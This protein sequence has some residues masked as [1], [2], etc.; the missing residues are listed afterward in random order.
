MTTL[1]KIKR[2]IENVKKGKYLRKITINEY[3]EYFKLKGYQNVHSL[4]LDRATKLYDLEKQKVAEIKKVAKQNNI[5]VSKKTKKDLINALIKSKTKHLKY[6]E[7]HFKKENKK[8]MDEYKQIIKERNI[9]KKYSLEV[10]ANI[11]DNPSYVKDNGEWIKAE[12]KNWYTLNFIIQNGIILTNIR[13][14]KQ[15]EKG[16]IGK[17]HPEI[18]I[19]KYIKLIDETKD[20]NEIKWTVKNDLTKD[21]SSYNTIN[22]YDEYGNFNFDCIWHYITGIFDYGGY[23]KQIYK[24]DIKDLKIINDIKTAD[25]KMKRVSFQYKFLNSLNGFVETEYDDYYCA[26]RYILEECSGKERLIK[27]TEKEF[28]KQLNRLSINFSKGL[29]TNDILKWVKE[30]YADIISMHAISPLLTEFRRH[31]APNCIVNLVYIVNNEHLYPIKNEKLKLFISK[32]KRVDE[33]IFLKFNYTGL[34]YININDENQYNDLLNSK[35]NNA[36]VL[37]DDVEK[38]ATDYINKNNMLLVPAS[39]KIQNSKLVSFITDNGVIVESNCDYESRK[40]ICQTFKGLYDCYNLEFRNQTYAQLALELFNIFHGKL[41]NSEYCEETRNSFDMFNI[42]PLSSTLVKNFEYDPNLDIALDLNRCY[43]NAMIHNTD[44]YPVFTFIDEIKDYDDSDIICGLYLVDNVVIEKLGGLRFPKQWI[45]YTEVKFMLDNDLITKQNILQYIKATNKIAANKLGDFMKLLMDT[46]PSKTFHDDAKLLCN[47]FIGSLGKKYKNIDSGFITNSWDQTC[48]SYLENLNEGKEFT[49][50]S[51][52]GLYFCRT[53]EKIRLFSDNVPIY[54][55]ILSYSHI[56]LYKTILTFYKQGNSQLLGYK[57]DFIYIRK[58]QLL[59]PIEI[60]N[61]MI[62]E[63]KKNKIY[64]ENGEFIGLIDP[65]KKE[66][67]MPIEVEHPTF[68]HFDNNPIGIKVQFGNLPVY[69]KFEPD[70]RDHKLVKKVWNVLTSEYKDKS[71][72]MQGPAGSGKTTELVAIYIEGSTIILC[73]TNKACNNIK[74]IFKKLGKEVKCMTFDSKF[75]VPDEN[76]ENN[77]NPLFNQFG[78]IERIEIDE[79]SMVPLKFWTKLCKM[80]QNNPNLIVQVYGDYNQC[81]STDSFY[82][83]IYE[84]Q[85]LKFLCD[86]NLIIKEFMPE[87]GRYDKET[88]MVLKYLI[89]KGKIHPSLRGKKIKGELLIN[90][91]K[92]N[93]TR[94]WINNKCHKFVYGD[95]KG[96]DMFNHKRL[97]IIS[98]YSDDYVSKSQFY[99]IVELNKD[100][101]SISETPNGPPIKTKEGEI[102]WVH[103]L[104]LMNKYTKKGNKPE[105]GLSMDLGYATTCYK[106]QGSTIEEPFNI[107]NIKNMTLNELYTSLSRA[108]KLSDINFNYDEI[109][110]QVFERSTETNESFFIKPKQINKGEI[111]ELYNKVIDYYYIG[112]TT[113]NT[114]TR[115]NEHINNKDD[116]LHKFGNI[117]D[118]VS[119]R[120]CYVYYYDIYELRNI[121]RNYTIYYSTKGKQLVNSQNLPK[122]NIKYNVENAV[123]NIKQSMD[124]KIREKYHINICN[125]AVLLKWTEDNK[126]LEKRFRSIKVGVD[127]AVKKAEE[128]KN[129]MIEEDNKQSIF[130]T[131]NNC[132]CGI[133]KDNICYCSNP[134][135]QVF[136]VNNELICIS[137]NKWKC[138]C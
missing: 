125:G 128:V 4:T 123:E 45:S 106:W 119:K 9:N 79:F 107:Y 52:N 10:K 11:I 12:R 88:F 72:V 75:Y 126:Q 44:S 85:C 14:T 47:S 76:D 77:K 34:D 104:Y 120:L 115:F 61:K 112:M 62:E 132:K 33:N 103:K 36:V 70:N 20:H 29:S 71:F 105:S 8:L 134:N 58:P 32:A 91:C 80:K 87:T 17:L 54:T 46:L 21:Y 81:T 69:R 122:S 40:R 55:H 110:D 83:N 7:T 68:K 24:L 138:R 66:G 43:A 51:L 89:E 59:N 27:L 97:K 22:V 35:I 15:K 117:T 64:D 137:C 50:T 84:K 41:T 16:E 135:Y 74:F 118:W 94:R 131:G 121:E 53:T 129:K 1:L 2:N 136:K 102:Y 39:M 63:D 26:I 100:C 49:Y 3:K 31:I 65:H 23:S 114:E 111:Y 73:Y 38:T 37:V 86:N 56:M 60:M 95:E 25:I 99:Y 28:L 109:E 42:K 82:F 30:Y 116:N 6:V 57:T 98:N 124:I 93:N 48:S 101:Y 92:F 67:E 18:Y 113:T 127:N 90:I 108:T 96:L 130:Y 5:N 78:N 133:N 13:K 19:N